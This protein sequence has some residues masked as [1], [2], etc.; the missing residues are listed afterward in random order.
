MKCLRGF[1][2]GSAKC[3]CSST[4]GGGGA[5]NALNSVYVVCTQSLDES[6]EEENLNHGCVVCKVLSRSEVCSEKYILLLFRL[7]LVLIAMK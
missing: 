2:G 4:R 1:R 5:K 7:E 3:L 6:F